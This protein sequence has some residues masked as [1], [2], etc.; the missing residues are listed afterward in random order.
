MPEILVEEA[1]VSLRACFSSCIEIR[2]SIGF[3]KNKNGYLERE[4]FD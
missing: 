3:R 2:N 4:Y 1:I